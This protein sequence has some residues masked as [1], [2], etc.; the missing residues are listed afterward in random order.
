MIRLRVH[1]RAA[2]LDIHKIKELADR[3]G[4]HYTTVSPLWK[5]TTNDR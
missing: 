5:N 2:A 1:Q 3:A 4:I